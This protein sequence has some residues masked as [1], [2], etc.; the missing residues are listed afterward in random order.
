MMAVFAPRSSGLTVNLTN[1]TAENIPSAFCLHGIPTSERGGQGLAVPPDMP[2]Y[3]RN[4]SERFAHLGLRVAVLD[5]RFLQEPCGG[6]LK[7]IP[8]SVFVNVSGCC[9]CSVDLES[10][11]WRGHEVRHPHEVRVTPWTRTVASD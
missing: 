9:G 3:C 11:V 5:S 10:S 7:L 8:P 6:E 1:I 4:S 2:E